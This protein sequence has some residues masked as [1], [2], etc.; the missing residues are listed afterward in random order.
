MFCSRWR[1]RGLLTLW[2]LFG[3]SRYQGPHYTEDRK[4][5]LT[6]HL[7]VYV[8]CRVMPICASQWAGIFADTDMNPMSCDSRTCDWL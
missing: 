4:V 7:L 5:V 2:S 3:Y 8:I 1:G 6:F